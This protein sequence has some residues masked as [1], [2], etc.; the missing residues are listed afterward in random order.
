[1]LGQIPV[2]QWL[3]HVAPQLFH[4]DIPCLVELG[5]QQPPPAPAEET[6]QRRPPRQPGEAWESG[7]FRHAFCRVG[8]GKNG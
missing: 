8:P 3:H 7:E 4:V 2:V 1:M 6:G 5:D